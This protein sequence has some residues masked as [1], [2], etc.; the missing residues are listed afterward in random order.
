MRR[1]NARQ[2]QAAV[3]ELAKVGEE[4][5]RQ[6]GLPAAGPVTLDLDSSDT[7][8]YG[9]HKQG[10][11]FNHRRQRCYHSQ[12]ATWAERRRILAAGAPPPTRVS[13]PDV[14][15]AAHAKVRYELLFEPA[16]RRLR[17]DARVAKRKM[18]NFGVKRAVHRQWPQPTRLPSEAVAVILLR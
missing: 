2:W 3:S 1:L 18:S 9:R 10:A 13:P 6:L 11:A 5:D 15:A 8:V 7:E 4:V 16:A 12:L 17:A 14:L